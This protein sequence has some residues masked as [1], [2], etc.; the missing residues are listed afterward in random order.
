MRI[1]SWDGKVDLPYEAVALSVKS[2]VD[3]FHVIADFN[4][5]TYYLKNYDSEEA[6]V[7]AIEEARKRYA[8]IQ[9]WK[10]KPESGFAP[11]FYYQF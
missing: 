9:M 3:G 2:E 8:E 6:A 4:G 10:A 11:L 7:R 5:K 1:V